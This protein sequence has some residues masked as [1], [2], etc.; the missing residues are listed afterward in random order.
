[1][2]WFVW[3]QYLAGPQQHIVVIQKKH[4][5]LDRGEGWAGRE[6][7]HDTSPERMLIDPQQKNKN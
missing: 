3:F 1:M 2:K 5:E 7:R 4:H 6:V